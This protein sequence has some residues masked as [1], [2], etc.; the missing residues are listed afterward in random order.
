MP[1]S[2]R[3][4]A[5]PR[6]GAR[7][8]YT[9]I[10]V[11]SGSSDQSAAASPST[12]S[13]ASSAGVLPRAA[14]SAAST[15]VRTCAVV[16]ALALTEPLAVPEPAP[17]N[18][19]TVTDTPCMTPLVVSVLFAQRRLALLESRTRTMQESAVDAF[20]ACSTR[21]CGVATVVI[22]SSFRPGGGLRPRC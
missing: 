13:A 10:E 6:A 5:S 15:S 19:T 8:E 2:A 4:K 3:P 11:R 22:W 12:S 20:S 18:D 21:S 9:S 7:S 16:V 1:L 17:T 14:A